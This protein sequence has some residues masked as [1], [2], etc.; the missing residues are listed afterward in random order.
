MAQT[1]QYLVPGG[2]FVNEGTNGY[3]YLIPGGE[4]INETTSADTGA[5]A[6]AKPTTGLLLLGVGP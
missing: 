5:A 2:E 4:Y 3:E 6:A 1:R